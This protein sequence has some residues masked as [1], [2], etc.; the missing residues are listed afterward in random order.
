MD[1]SSQV[2][3]T[4]ANVNNSSSGSSSS[5]GSIILEDNSNINKYFPIDKGEHFTL[6]KVKVL[7][8]VNLVK[9]K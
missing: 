2:T 8:M 1:N 6:Y 5:N 9:L 3:I 4:P 7:L